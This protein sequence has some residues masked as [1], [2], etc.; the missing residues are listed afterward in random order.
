MY[1]ELGTELKINEALTVGPVESFQQLL[2]EQPRWI[3]D[4][5]QICPIRTRQTKVQ[6]N[7][8][9]NQ[10]CAQSPQQQ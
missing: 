5:F 4:F 2:A 9:N 8:E 1:T 7:R 6:Q 3:R 10:R